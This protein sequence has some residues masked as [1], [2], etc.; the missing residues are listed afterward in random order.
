[1]SARRLRVRV[2]APPSGLPSYVPLT[3]YQVAALSTVTNNKPKWIDAVDPLYDGGT[4]PRPYSVRNIANFSGGFADP[5]QRYLYVNGGGHGDSAYNGILRFDLNGT[6]QAAGWS[7]VSGSETPFAQ[8]PQGIGV[9][10][11]TYPDEKAGSIHS[12]DNM[13][14]DAVSNTMYRFGGSYWDYGGA[15]DN[16]ANW[17]FNFSTGEWVRVGALVA[18]AFGQHVDCACAYDPVTRKAML[19]RGGNFGQFYRVP[20]ETAGATFAAPGGAYDAVGAYDPTRNRV[21]HIVNGVLQHTTVNWS[22]ESINGWSNF[23]A[24]GDTAALLDEAMAIWYDALLDRFWFLGAR[25]VAITKIYWIDA[26]DFADNAV[27]VNSTPLLNTSGQAFTIPAR[28]SDAGTFFGLYKR[29]CWIP[30]WRAVAVA[31]TYDY[32]VHVIKLPSA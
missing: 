3:P 30:E 32:P 18:G 1:M 23:T 22:A 25:R 15:P 20:T 7:V 12:Y 6:A 4:S 17:K 28:V 21:L 13:V 24:T 8:I 2:V 26:A 11:I 16:N 27:T 31:T 19:W 9:N 10:H 14:F 29:F 5:A